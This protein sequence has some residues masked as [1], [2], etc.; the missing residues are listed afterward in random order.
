MSEC[1][2]TRFK[3]FNKTKFHF[4]PKLKLGVSTKK[5]IMMQENPKHP[6]N[7]I[8][9]KYVVVSREVWKQVPENHRSVRNERGI[10]GWYNKVYI[11]SPEA[12]KHLNDLAEK[13]VSERSAKSNKEN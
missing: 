12:A 4:L 9:S 13:K 10:G 7:G 3:N 11:I 2:S 5:N 6:L 8:G 1:K